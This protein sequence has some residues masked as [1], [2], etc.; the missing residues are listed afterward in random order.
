MAAVVVQVMGDF[1]PEVFENPMFSDVIG[2]CQSRLGGSN[3]F[4]QGRKPIAV[5]VVVTAMQRMSRPVSS[6]RPPPD[7]A[8]ECTC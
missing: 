1:N 4:S 5:T 7:I 2:V 3:L 6:L 8:L